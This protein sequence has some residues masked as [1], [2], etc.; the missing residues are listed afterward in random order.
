MLLLYFNVLQLY[1]LILAEMFNRRII[2]TL[3][4]SGRQA[5]LGANFAIYEPVIK[6]HD[7]PRVELPFGEGGHLAVQSRERKQTPIK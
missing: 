6:K 7:A 2:Y 1:L 5:A 4:N 3:N